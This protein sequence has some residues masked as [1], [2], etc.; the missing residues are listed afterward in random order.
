LSFGRSAKAF[1]Q[2]RMDEV[3]YHWWK[4]NRFKYVLQSNLNHVIARWNVIYEKFKLNA[5][6]LVK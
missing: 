5:F 2:T 4:D 6:A 1:P 3:V